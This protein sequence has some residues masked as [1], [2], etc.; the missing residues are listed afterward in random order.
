[1]AHS[2]EIDVD[3]SVDKDQQELHLERN[4]R[5]IKSSLQDE[6]HFVGET[7]EPA[8]ANNWSNRGA[9][10]YEALQFI[11]VGGIVHIQ[12][13][14]TAGN[15]LTIFV[16][17]VG[18]RPADR[19]RLIGFDITDTVLQQLKVL[20]NGSI[21]ATGYSASNIISFSISFRAG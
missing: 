19:L 4:F 2:D 21:D 10:V 17:P 6:P 8:F 11:K 12:G 13:Q 1:M 20:D 7:G 3:F 16:L 14:V 15:G 5:I 18:Y 9:G